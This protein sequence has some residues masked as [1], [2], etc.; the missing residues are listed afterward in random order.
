MSRILKTRSE[1]LFSLGVVVFLLALLFSLPDPEQEQEHQLMVQH[2]LLIE[3]EAKQKKLQEELKCLASVV[4]HEARGE[5]V[6]GQIAVA[7][8]VFNRV[9]SKHYPNTVCKVVFQPH[10]FTDHKKIK[11]DDTTMRIAEKVAFGVVDFYTKAT[12]YHADYVNPYWANS[13]KM[14][15]K[16]KIGK[17]LFYRAKWA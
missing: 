14:M 4:Y 11:Y 3:Q 7:Q 10:Q 1:E 12:H 9:K 6:L 5:P 2:D 13:E 8:V 17:H 16:T 15:F